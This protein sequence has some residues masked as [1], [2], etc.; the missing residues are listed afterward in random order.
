M[1][2][3]PSEELAYWVGVAQSDGC[4][5]RYVVK[6]TGR[7]RYFVSLRV[8]A[9]S[10]PMLRRFQEI[11]NEI[12]NRNVGIFKERKT[13]TW[14][15][16]LSVNAF[17]DVFKSL[18]IR[19]GDPPVPPAWTLKDASLFGAY[20]AGVIDGDGDVRVKRN[21]YPQCE[22]RISSGSRQSILSECIRRM[23]G[24]SACITYRER[25]NEIEGR[26]I[27]GHVYSLEF[28]ISSKNYKF[29]K[30]NVVPHIRITYKKGKIE[31][32]ISSKP[33]ASVAYPG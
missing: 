2:I 8:R 3:T 5:R 6:P 20:L 17:T 23:L 32:Y 15:F 18:G 9:K 1:T 7:V 14:M 22:I 24:C 27:H 10:M 25:D 12:F 11:S 16:A 28:Y 33:M 30:E 19:F 29:I 31:N 4:F 21:R 13:P 26:K